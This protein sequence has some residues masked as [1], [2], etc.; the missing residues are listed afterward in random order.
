MR[1]MCMYVISTEADLSFQKEL[2]IDNLSLNL[3]C[4]I[5]YYIIYAL[6]YKSWYI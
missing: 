6:L 3:F 4:P 1:G 5:I 2:D